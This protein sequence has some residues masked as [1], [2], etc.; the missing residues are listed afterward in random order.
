MLQIIV[1]C[2]LLDKIILIALIAN[3]S[4]GALHFVVLFVGS[5]ISIGIAELFMI[6]GHR[7]VCCD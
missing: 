3:L 2:A 7:I 1:N 5:V 4:F 6:P